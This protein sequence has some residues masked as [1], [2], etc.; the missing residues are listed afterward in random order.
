MIAFMIIF[1][2]LWWKRRRDRSGRSQRTIAL[3]RYPARAR[4]TLW[5]PGWAASAHP[6][7]L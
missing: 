3:P 4:S 7:V 1:S 2:P 6:P 5:K